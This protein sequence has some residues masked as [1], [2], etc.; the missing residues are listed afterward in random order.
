MNCLKKLTLELFANFSQRMNIPWLRQ[1]DFRANTKWYFLGAIRSQASLTED[2]KPRNEP[3][4]KILLWTFQAW[5]IG[6]IL[7]SEVCVEENTFVIGTWEYDPILKFFIILSSRIL[8]SLVPVF[9]LDEWIKTI[10]TF[11]CLTIHW[12]LHSSILPFLE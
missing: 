9:Y 2:L 6:Y 8:Y 5:I 12:S 1:T 10:I 3:P 7:N 4:H 11:I